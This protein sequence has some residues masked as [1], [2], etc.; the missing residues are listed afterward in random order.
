VAGNALPRE[1]LQLEFYDF[2]DETT[3]SLEQLREHVVAAIHTL[4]PD[5]SSQQ[6]FRAAEFGQNEQEQRFRVEGMERFIKDSAEAAER[7]HVMT[8]TTGAAGG[9]RKQNDD[10]P[11]VEAQ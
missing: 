11:Q 4:D 6:V 5:A 8:S 7:A 10:S 2:V 9:S 1:A 3:Q